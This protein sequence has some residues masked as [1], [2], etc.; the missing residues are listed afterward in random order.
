MV[1][2]RRILPL[3]GQLRSRRGF[4]SKQ[5][6]TPP[7]G[8]PDVKPAG[9]GGGAMLPI[10]VIASAFSAGSFFDYK[11]RSD[12]AFDKSMSASYPAVVNVF[13]SLFGHKS[14]DAVP[15]NKASATGTTQISNRHVEVSPAPE[16]VEEARVDHQASAETAVGSSSNV[17]EEK[18]EPPHSK[19][20]ASLSTSSTGFD[21]I[22]ATD[23]DSHRITITPSAGVAA[24]G[25]AVAV[26]VVDY[27]HLAAVPAEV[28]AQNFKHDIATILLNE[29]NEQTASFKHEL[30]ETL[31][32]D[33]QT[34]DE[35]ALRLRVA[36]LSSEFFE[37]SKWE[38]IRLHQSL[39]QLEHDITRRYL[40]LLAEQRTQLEAEVRRALFAKEKDMAI[41]ADRAMHSAHARFELQLQDA[42]RV[43]AEA[44][45]KKMQEELVAMETKLARDFENQISVMLTEERQKHIESL[46]AQQGKIS[47]VEAELSILTGIVESKEN[48]K[49]LSN[50]LHKQSS[51]IL[52]L[53]SALTDSRSLAPEVSALKKL[54]KGDA[55]LETVVSSIPAAA[56]RGIPTLPDL[57]ARFKL[58]QSEV[59]KHA[60]APEAAPKIVGQMVGSVLAMASSAPKGFV[61]GGGLEETL[62]RSAHF[63]DNGDLNGAVLEL[64]DLRGYAKVLLKDW[65]MEAGNRLAAEEAVKLL[66]AGAAA[67]HFTLI[68][69]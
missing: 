29:L 4:S 9:G 7:A 63:L 34:L 37:R 17:H 27:S 19:V 3:R 23:P 20:E 32:K 22:V 59:R 46:T 26:P 36:K 18:H 40:D 14:K 68:D 50:S 69:K 66:R 53:E 21:A 24:T 60:L 15:V 62:A 45:Q 39:R 11:L 42:L 25:A 41:D 10:I 2:L 44:A 38:G 56:E 43:Q 1:F 55:F 61:E 6:Q 12:E 64:K 5:T 51:A 33:L 28:R 65:E 35:H 31:L 47:G 13:K 58:V 49:M 16:A 54:C 67:R 8:F 57:R 30:E 52:A 48:L